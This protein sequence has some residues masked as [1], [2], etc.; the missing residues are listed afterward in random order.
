MSKRSFFTK[1]LF[2]GAAIVA[3]SAATLT[4]VAQD[5]T[6]AGD[7]DDDARRRLST[8]TVTATKIEENVQDVSASITAVNE[9]ALDFAGIVDPKRLGLIV[10]GLNVGYS[11][12]EARIAMRG[13]RTNNVGPEAAQVVGIFNDGAYVATTTQVLASY[14]DLN[15]VE[16]LRGPQGTLYGR[17]TFAG[18]IN[19]ISNE[20]NFDEL[21]GSAE[22][23][24][25]D[26]NLKR[27]EGVLNVPVS[28]TFALRFAGMGEVHDG[29]IE[30][31]YREGPGDDLHNQD[32]MAFRATAK[33]QPND[34]FDATLRWT[35]T[36]QDT[37]GSAIWGYQQIG[38][39]RNNQDATTSTGL[40]ANST[41]LS[42]H[43]YQ[44]G[45]NAS[46]RTQAGG[47]AT[48][49]DAGP[50]SVSRD[51]LSQSKQ[52]GDSINLQVNYDLGWADLSVIGAYD[53]YEN[54]QFYDG[55][56]SNGAYDGGDALSNG[57]AGYDTLQESLSGE[58]RLASQGAGPLEWLVGG[59]WFQSEADWQFGFLNNGQYQRYNTTTSDTFE[60]ESMA[61]F[62]N[63]TYSLTDSFRVLGGLRWND[64][65]NTLKGGATGGTSD[66]LVWKAGAEM[67]FGDD[68]LLYATASTG[69]RIG[70]VNGSSLVAAGAPASYDPETVTAYEAGIKSTLFDGD[71]TLNVA[72]YHNQYRD[73]HAQSFVTAC[74]DPTNPAT[75]IASE[76][77]ENAGEVDATGFEVEAN[78]LPGD[79]WFVNGTLALQDAEFGEYLVGR[80]NGLGN[81]EG[82]QD[83]TMTTGEIVAAGGVPALSLE[84]WRPALT[85]EVSASLQVGYFFDL[86]NGNTITPLFQTAYS[87]EYYGFDF[88]V[89]GS[90]QGS[91]TK[92]DLRVTWRN[93]NK[94]FEVEGFVENIEDEA[95]LT[96][97][98]IFTPSQADVATASIQANYS[99][100]RIWG[101]RLGVDF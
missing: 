74:I 97:A 61:I 21:E 42:G 53:E 26:Y 22:V 3:L 1:S 51:A 100:P 30:N 13:A 69:Y 34:V 16:V 18:T 5:D 50:Y 90:E 36:E 59:F 8:V 70:G 4:A 56:Y 94:G 9:E 99:D 92:S 91:F 49:Q 24:L 46:G 68:E 43:C 2:G 72:L 62:G 73:M 79:N 27:L 52:S 19:I 93:E 20:P 76:Y 31:T 55:D 12:N 83:V 77:T 37:N 33:W 11:G 57:F 80:V 88:N 64:D 47:A 58:I 71:L 39:Y 65:E 7:A 95:V 81:F 15:R 86:G 75:C 6:A 89:P 85:P 32:V 25:G 29:Y 40:S 41:F 87:G 23:T 66:E 101:V 54:L 10:P 38:C 45:P 96:R 78:W 84:G 28:D 14:L 44:P 48:E 98:I 67:D 60:T 63:A 17:N 82:R 35:T